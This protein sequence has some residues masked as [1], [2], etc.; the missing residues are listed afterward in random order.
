MEMNKLVNLS[1]INKGAVLN[2]YCCLNYKK[3]RGSNGYARFDVR[4]PDKNDKSVQTRKKTS[5]HDRFTE[6][7]KVRIT[8]Y[9]SFTWLQNIFEI[10]LFIAPSQNISRCYVNL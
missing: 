9:A 4:F 1:K 6:E 3:S 8:F 5:S 10:I 2:A 7:V